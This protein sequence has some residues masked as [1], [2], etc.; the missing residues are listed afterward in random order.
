MA[1]IAQFGLLQSVPHG[2]A[3]EDAH[4]FPRIQLYKYI[5]FIW[6]ATLLTSQFLGTVQS[7]GCPSGLR[8]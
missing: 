6:G 1:D 4:N 7:A 5:S 2:T 3:F 8:A